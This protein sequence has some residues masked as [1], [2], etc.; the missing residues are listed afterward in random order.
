MTLPDRYSPQE[1]ESRTYKWWESQGF[2]KAQDVSTRPPYCIILPPP[3]VTG[4]LH[5]GHALDHTLQDILIRWKRMSGFNALWIPGTDHAG[6]AT[7][8][9]VERELK[10]QNLT[11][12]ELGRDEFVRRVWE[13]KHQYGGR[14]VEQMNELGVGL[15]ITGLVRPCDGGFHRVLRRSEDGAEEA[16]GENENG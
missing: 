4:Q 3:N 5:L 16:G 10:K 12:K 15:E 2:F 1:V 11:R 6:I 9:V 8:S 13:W 7:Q 14:I